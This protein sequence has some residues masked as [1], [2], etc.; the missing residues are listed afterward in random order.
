MEL[1]A[2]AR[3]LQAPSVSHVFQCWVLLPPVSPGKFK[4]TS[5]KGLTR[6]NVAP[7]ENN[8]STGPGCRSDGFISPLRG[9]IKI[10]PFFCLPEVHGAGNRLYLKDTKGYKSW[11]SKAYLNL[12]GDALW[13]VVIHSVDSL[14]AD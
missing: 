2:T 3:G 5:T 12:R 11:A 8:V 13:D 9:A 1:T 4:L 7:A 10:V 6:G 14:V